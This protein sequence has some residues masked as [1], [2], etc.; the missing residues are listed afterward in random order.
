MRSLVSLSQRRSL[1]VVAIALLV[2]TAPALCHA[3]DD[4]FPNLPTIAG[5]R[6]GMSAQK[7]Y[8]IMKAEAGG[9]QI[10]LGEYPTAGVSAKP[11]PETF[12]VSI[13]NQVPALTIQV[14]L[15][16]P[17]SKQTV[18][19]V[20]ELLQYPDS[21]HLLTSTVLTSWRQKFGK[22][23]DLVNSAS[24][25]WALDEQGQH[26]PDPHNCFE[27]ANTSIQV[28]APQGAVYP[29]TTALYEGV[30]YNTPCNSFVDVRATLR[31][32]APNSRYTSRIQL[33]EIDHAALTR[34]QKLYHA[35]IAQQNAIQQKKQLKKAEQQQAPT[36]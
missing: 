12:S 21:D 15:T 10:G 28:E 22:P 30:V 5:I 9:A 29:Y 26:L 33:I 7:A 8:D 13:I 11:V 2:L 31:Y 25:Y 35:Y 14:W 20:G 19:A 16:T 18:W 32:L 36:Y 1:S 17:P 6:P 34:T 4:P 3:Q 24:A 27:G 23:N